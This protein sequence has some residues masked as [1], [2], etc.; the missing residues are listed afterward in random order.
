MKL[1]FYCW[2]H[3]C[4]ARIIFGSDEGQGCSNSNNNT[5]HDK[6]V[7]RR[8]IFFRFLFLFRLFFL[9]FFW[10]TFFFL[11][12][13]WYSCEWVCRDSRHIMRSF[14]D[15]KKKN[16]YAM[17]NEP[18][19]MNFEKKNCVS[20]KCLFRHHLSIALFYIF[21]FNCRCVSSLH[22]IRYTVHTV[23]IV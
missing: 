3:T 6:F 23:Q 21:K 20:I 16:T 2:R 14:C 7:S 12:L 4:W 9:F 11:F 13:K 10:M 1:V 5:F 15:E 18:Y 17:H 19:D 8:G 22:S